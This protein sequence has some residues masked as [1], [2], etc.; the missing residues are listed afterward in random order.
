MAKHPSWVTSRGSSSSLAVALT[1]STQLR[2]LKETEEF[3]EERSKSPQ[4][5]TERHVAATQLPSCE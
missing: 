3:E 2:N 1:V 4:T 5:S